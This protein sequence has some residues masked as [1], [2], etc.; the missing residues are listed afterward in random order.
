MAGL[1]VSALAG[2]PLTALAHRQVVVLRGGQA[3]APITFNV[4][5]NSGG[6]RAGSVSVGGQTYSVTQAGF[7]CSY[8][9][10]PTSASPGDTGGNLS[11]SVSAPGGCAWTAV[12][13]V[14]W[15]TVHS[16]ASGSGGGVVVLTVAPNTGG[17]R[18]GTATIAGQTFTVNEGAMEHVVLLM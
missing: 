9:I 4:A 11:V 18:S 7:S 15:V 6:A 13:N 10:G 17:P 2:L 8:L 14:P 3:P 16:G 5:A 12:S 1:L